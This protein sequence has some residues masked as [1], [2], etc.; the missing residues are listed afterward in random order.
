MAKGWMEYVTH[1]VK[2]ILIMAWTVHEGYRGL[3]LPHLKEN[4]I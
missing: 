1:M 4:L 2:A 3:R